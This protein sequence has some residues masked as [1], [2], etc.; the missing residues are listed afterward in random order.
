M[1]NLVVQG[2]LEEYLITQGYQSSTVV[3][4]DSSHYYYRRRREEDFST[5]LGLFRELIETEVN[6]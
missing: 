6:P 3:G 4:G 2:F 1:V 5:V